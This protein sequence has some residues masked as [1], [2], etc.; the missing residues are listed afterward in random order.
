MI[1][2]IEYGNIFDELEPSK[3]IFLNIGDLPD[4]SRCGKRHDQ[5]RVGDEQNRT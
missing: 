5:R 1:A 2:Q 3:A 4:L